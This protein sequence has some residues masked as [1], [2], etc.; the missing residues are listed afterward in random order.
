MDL[1]KYG[2]RQEEYDA[3]RVAL[4]RDPNECELRILGVMWSEHCSYKSTKHLLRL[5]PSKGPSVVLGPGENAGIVDLGGGLGGAFKAESHNH[6]SAVEPYHGAATGIGGV[7]RDIFAL[8][9]KPVAAMDGIFLGDPSHPRT[10]FLASGIVSGTSDYSRLVEV[11]AVGGKTVYDRSFNENPLVNAFCLGIVSL[12]SIISSKT[13]LPGQLVAI[14]GSKTGRE[15]IAGAAFASV[16]LAD[17]GAGKPASVQTGD[18]LMERRLIEACLEMNERGLIVSMQDMGAA[19]ITSSSSE[20]AAKSGVGMKLHFEKT[21][22]KEEDMEAWEIALS[23]TQERMLLII[24]PEKLEEA[25]S[26]A[27]K[28]DL[29]WAVIGETTAEKEYSIYFRG[30][31]AASLPAELIADGCPPIRWASEKPAGFEDRWN[32]DLDGLP[33]P[34]DWNKAMTALM[35][36]PSLASKADIYGQLDSAVQGNTFKGPGGPV[37][38]IRIEGRESLI[39]MTLD[40]DPWKCGLDP[41]RGGAETAARTIRALSVAGAQPLGL[42]DCLNFPSPEIPG[43]MWTLEECIKGIAEACTA[44]GCPVVSGNVSLYNETAGGA[45]LPTPVAGTVGVIPTPEDYLPSGEWAE[46][47]ML[48]MVGPI[49]SSLAGSHYIRSLGMAEGGRPL[50]FSGE[51]E[52]DFSERALKTAR[53]HVARSGRAIAGG[54]LAAALIKDGAGS[55]M[56]ASLALPVPTRKDVVLFGEGGARALYAVPISKLPLFRSLWS[57]YPVLELG[58]AGGDALS[59]EGTF[60]F[61]VD[62]LTTLWRNS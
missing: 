23:E 51:A 15:G 35:A 42:T 48:I 60:S 54:G 11:P 25:A 5:F 6:P 59:V 52:K 4:G 17:D 13:A 20:V 45:I 61:T 57:G 22:L 16:E 34:G 46:G 36:L 38:V 40:A 31:L 14:L 55:G 58:R 39:A 47:D 24:E 37:S 62:E 29:H 41:F 30:E 3:A 49:N 43:Q 27:R 56:G 44:L 2:L 8:G 19:G 33:L 32:F 10:D 28:W 7:I 1:N 21:P 12:D 9:A 18:P 50:L 53:K 26:V